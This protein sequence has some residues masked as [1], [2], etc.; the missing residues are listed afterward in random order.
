MGFD[1]PR[2]LENQEKSEA[3]EYDTYYMET[4][5]NFKLENI[6][7]TQ[8]MG[9]YVSLSRFGI[10][11]PETGA[12]IFPNSYSVDVYLLPEEEKENSYELA[13][14]ASNETICFAV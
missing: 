1:T 12:G 11:T 5:A 4:F 8:P 10:N 2:D 3:R 6:Q 14:T 9:D 13:A 7:L